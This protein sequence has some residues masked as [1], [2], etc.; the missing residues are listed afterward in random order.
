[1][2]N[3]EEVVSCDKLVQVPKTRSKWVQ[4]FLQ[5]YPE[6]QISPPDSDLGL[7][8]LSLT[9]QDTVITWSPFARFDPTHQL[10][11]CKVGSK[12]VA[13][14]RD[15]P[16]FLTYGPYS[17]AI[18]SGEF[19]AIF[20]LEFPNFVDWAVKYGDDEVIVVLDVACKKD[21]D[22]RG[23][24]ESELRGFR[25]NVVT[26]EQSRPDERGPK[27][28]CLT[29]VDMHPM[30]RGGRRVA[31]GK[32]RARDLG[33]RLFFEGRLRANRCMHNRQGRANQRCVF[34][35]KVEPLTSPNSM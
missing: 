23:N 15:G 2:Q 28:R 24:H 22:G 16:G 18:P 29:R 10:I 14:A 12:H 27:P 31:D 26:R 11:G 13:F 35:P 21:T 7:G 1:M 25:H 20:R 30:G 3:D 5:T 4:L 6:F 32:R 17:D 8:L 33:P 19:V 9:S 34:S